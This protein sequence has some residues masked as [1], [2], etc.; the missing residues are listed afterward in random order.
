MNKKTLMI[1]LGLST[2][3]FILLNGSAYAATTPQFQNEEVY[4]TMTGTIDEIDGKMIFLEPEEGGGKRRM[5]SVNKARE[6]GLRNFKV[7]DMITLELDRDN[8][9]VDLYK[10]KPKDEQPQKENMR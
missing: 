9:I 7:G 1:S 8:L 6:E 2:A 5:F 3:L 10:G 4:T